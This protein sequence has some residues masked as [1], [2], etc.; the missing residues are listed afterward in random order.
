MKL[1]TR[2]STALDSPRFWGN[3]LKPWFNVE[4]F[5]KQIDDRIGLNRDGRSIVRLVWAQE[6][7][8]NI[9]G[10]STPRYW[11][12]R[13][14]VSEGKYSY[15]TVARWVLEIR[16]EPETYAEAWNA[17]R[18][19]LHDPTTGGNFVCQDCGRKGDPAIFKSKVP[20]T[21]EE[22]EVSIYCPQCLGKNVIGG[23]VIDKGPPPKEYYS[24]LSDCAEHESTTD[25]NGRPM[26]CVRAMYGETKWG[27]R[28]MRCWGSY[29]Q[30]ND[31]DLQMISR[32]AENMQANKE[33]A[34]YR[35]ISP[36]EL[37]EIELASNM[38]VEAENERME[39]LEDEMVRDFMRT[40]GHRLLTDDPGVL[41]HGKYHD[42]AASYQKGINNGI[43]LPD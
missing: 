36:A 14:R 30:P 8:Q 7:Y 2:V 17:T 6:V 34:M 19:S 42:T 37:A 3:N 28:G 40:H 18:Y 39:A 1:R 41:R 25:H 29:R 38:Q 22:I 32:L 31:L 11:L 26:C 15:L 33:R 12:K 16:H 9:W 10:E 21:D 35:P 27:S 24:Y 23:S 4:R 5:Q 20:D 43:V 13:V